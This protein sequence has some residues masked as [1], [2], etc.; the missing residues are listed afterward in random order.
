MVPNFPEVLN[1]WLGCSISVN[2][3]VFW[4][5]TLPDLH[6]SL[7]NQKTKRR[8]NCDQSRL[9]TACSNAF[10]L[11]VHLKVKGILISL[12]NS[13]YPTNTGSFICLIVHFKVWGFVFSS[14]FCILVNNVKDKKGCW[15]LHSFT[16]KLLPE[17]CDSIPCKALATFISSM[18]LKK[19]LIL[20]FFFLP[21][22]VLSFLL[23]KLLFACLFT[24]Q[25][26]Q[27]ELS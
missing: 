10:K 17:Q 23:C 20:S 9:I 1:W 27:G 2:V 16:I 4:E 19:V 25:D 14:D 11:S 13:I 5:L 22:I 24:W 15:T 3:W 21:D 8:R 12:F 6:S 26:E 18:L 7:V